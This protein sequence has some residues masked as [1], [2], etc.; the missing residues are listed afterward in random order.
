MILSFLHRHCGLVTFPS[1]ASQLPVHMNGDEIKSYY[2]SFRLYKLYWTKRLKFGNKTIRFTGRLQYHGLDATAKL[3]HSS[4][5]ILE[6]W[7][8][9]FPFLNDEHRL[10]L[11]AGMESFFLMQ[12]VCMCSLVNGHSV[13][14]VQVLLFSSHKVNVRQQSVLTATSSL[15]STWFVSALSSLSQ[16]LLLFKH[17]TYTTVYSM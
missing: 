14:C 16:L 8:I 9:Q 5:P 6:A 1:C 15:T 11:P 4:A 13:R 2:H 7:R 17:L 3:L 10:L 12:T